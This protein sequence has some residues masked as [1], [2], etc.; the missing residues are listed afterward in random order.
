MKPEMNHRERIMAAINHQPT[1]RV[2]ID[3]WGV[4]EVTGK[5]MKRYN[6]KDFFG[7][8]KAMDLDKIMGV[9]PTLLPGRKD[10]WNIEWKTIPLA[11]GAGFYQ[12]PVCFPIGKYETIDEIEA[13]YEW[14][15]VDMYDYSTIR[16]QCERIRGEGYAIEGGYISITY[17]YEMIRGTEQCLLDFAA[18]E[19]LADYILYKINEFASAHTR[20][21]LEAADGLVDVTQVTDDFGSQNGLLMSQQ[22]I[23][24]YTGRYYDSNIAQAREFGAKV[25]HHDDGAVAELIPWIVDKGCQILNPIQWHLP[26]W[27]LAGIK[28]RFGDKLCFHGGMDNQSVLPFKGP[29]E[30]KAEVRACI[31]ALYS[32]QTGYILAPCHNLQA[33]TPLENIFTMYDYAKEYSQTIKR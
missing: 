22:M 1:D 33:I 14:P 13:N 12:E 2:P 5:L 29:E 6:V 23:E 25:F 20:R 11:N 32:D 15:S 21:I 18:D 9:G 17:F 24:R 26:G 10:M 3:Y 4:D 19:E 30:V 16:E 31:D 7:L 8:V 28:K 27:D